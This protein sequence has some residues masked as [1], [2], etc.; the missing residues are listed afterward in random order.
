MFIWL[1]IIT[2]YTAHIMVVYCFPKYFRRLIP[3]I[4]N[5]E[6]DELFPKSINS[7]PYPT[8]VLSKYECQ[9]DCL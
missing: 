5:N 7:N 6:V 9:V 1:P 2:G 8:E 4:A 3:S